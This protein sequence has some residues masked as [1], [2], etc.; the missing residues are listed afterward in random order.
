MSERAK[1]I[2]LGVSQGL[3]NLNDIK[4][5]YNNFARGGYTKWK[6]RIKE[7]K[8][9]DIDNDPTYDYE[10]FYNSD[11]DRAWYPEYG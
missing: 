5:G 2:Q 6:E 1:V 7:H 11:P 3:T 4:K 10:V 9:I 8:N